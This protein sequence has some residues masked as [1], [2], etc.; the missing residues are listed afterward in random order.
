M[1]NSYYDNVNINK[2]L[3]IT[4]CNSYSSLNNY[5]DYFSSNSLFK[6]NVLKE[7]IDFGEDLDLKF[8][9]SLFLKK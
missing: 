1:K 6:K 4:N 8:D 2:S 5:E 9:E 3:P 7:I